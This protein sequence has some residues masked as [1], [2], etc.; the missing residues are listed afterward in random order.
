LEV[1]DV[2]ADICGFTLVLLALPLV[3][4]VVALPWRWGSIGPRLLCVY[5]ADSNARRRAVDVAMMS[6]GNPEGKSMATSAGMVTVDT[7]PRT[8]SL[9]VWQWG[10]G[11]VQRS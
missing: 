1:V 11:F 3:D 2:E 4:D 7:S 9:H 6:V 10:G 8:Q 5:D